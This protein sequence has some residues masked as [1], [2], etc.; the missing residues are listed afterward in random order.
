MV[1]GGVLKDFYAI[2]G[3]NKNSDNKSIKHAYRELAKKYHPDRNPDNEDAA[4]R[5][6]EVSEAYSVLSDPEKRH[7]YDAQGYGGNLNSYESFEDLFRN[8]G[9][10]PF[11]PSWRDQAS[12][13]H[14]ERKPER[15][16]KTINLSLSI[17]E[18]FS[19]GKKTS[20]KVRVQRNCKV[21]DGRGGEIVKTC[22]DCFGTG[23]VNKLVR[24]GPMMVKTSATCSQCMGRGKH[25]SKI[26]F[27]CHGS[28]KIKEIEEY[29]ISIKTS[30]K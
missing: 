23:K 29:D 17:D 26:C 1:F 9:F 30:K 21:C 11:E 22:V 14:E 19:G 6:K 20:V 25:I 12:K 5:F 15:K 24:N 8:A 4:E 10:N 16:N 18:L 2:L 27:S 3:V 28:G 7:E 13:I